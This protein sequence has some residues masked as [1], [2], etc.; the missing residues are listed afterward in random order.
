MAENILIAEDDMTQCWLL[1][2]HLRQ[3]GYSV[4]IARDGREAVSL[5]QT[6]ACRL[7]LMDLNMPMMDGVEATRLIRNFERSKAADAVPIIAM[8]EHTDLDKSIPFGMS[9]YLRKPIVRDEL[10]AVLNESDCRCL[11]QKRLGL[12]PGKDL[13]DDKN[14]GHNQSGALR[15]SLLRQRRRSSG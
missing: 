4:I 7:I 9:G 5:V 13:G 8:K 2:S 1:E 6:A 10:Q 11:I 15:S 12:E 14:Q 3:L